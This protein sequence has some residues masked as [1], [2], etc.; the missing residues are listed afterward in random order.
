MRLYRIQD[1]VVL[2][3]SSFPPACLELNYFDIRHLPTGMVAMDVEE[4]NWTWKD[5]TR[6]ETQIIKIGEIRKISPNGG[7][8]GVIGVFDRTN[9]KHLEAMVQAAI[10]FGQPHSMAEH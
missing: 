9:L 8:L 10:L 6:N 2:R 3:F 1:Y 5:H 4:E 7:R